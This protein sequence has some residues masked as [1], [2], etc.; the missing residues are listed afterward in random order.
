MSAEL[1]ETIEIPLNSTVRKFL[2][3]SS[4]FTILSFSVNNMISSGI[5]RRVS[6]GDLFVSFSGG[7]IVG[8]KLGF[9]HVNIDGG[10]RGLSLP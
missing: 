6:A 10:S 3:I 7:G 2:F 8:T 5:I 4:K 1:Q 9:T